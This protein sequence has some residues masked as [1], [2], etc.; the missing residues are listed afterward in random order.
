MILYPECGYYNDE[1]GDPAAPL[2]GECESCYRKDTCRSAFITTA[3]FDPFEV[4][5]LIPLEKLPN[6]IGKKILVA[7]PNDFRYGRV[8]TVEDV[9]VEKQI[10]WLI[11]DF[12]CHE[13]GRVWV[14]YEYPYSSK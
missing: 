8:A 3:G 10:L 7:P 11:N 1:R 14:A 4:G 9:N 5:D 13:Y 12:T 6:Y 2:N